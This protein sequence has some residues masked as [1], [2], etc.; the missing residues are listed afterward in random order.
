MSTLKE[1]IKEGDKKAKESF[2]K[3]CQQQ[4][5]NYE[6]KLFKK[7]KELYCLHCDGK[8]SYR[9]R[10]TRQ[11]TLITSYGKLEV[12]IQQIDCRQCG[13]TSRPT[14]LLLGIKP[15]QRITQEYLDKA[16]ETALHTSYQTASKTTANYTDHQL[17]PRRIRQALLLKSKQLEEQ[18]KK[19]KCK[20]YKAFLKD[21]TKVRTGVT[22]RGSDITIV[23][24]VEGRKLTVNDDGVITKQRLVGE[25]LRV[26]VGK[27]TTF[28]EMQH[29]TKHVMTDGERG[30]DNSIKK[31]KKS[32]EITIHRCSWHLSRALGYSL[33]R[34]GL[35]K[36]ER[37]PYVVALNRIVYY[38]AINYRTYYEELVSSHSVIVG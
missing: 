30:I 8:N 16:I 2:Q 9:K 13:K 31:L 36:K 19:N 18:E 11:R 35:S 26:V 4:I 34:D 7:Q 24:G 15:R 1:I 5:K 37:I 28:D 27:D 12:N 38:S 25:I 23:Y 14:L 33:W 6:R 10:G 20:E 29:T 17:S 22:T 21:S 32:E 3:S